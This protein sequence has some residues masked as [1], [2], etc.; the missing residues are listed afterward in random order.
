MFRLSKKSSI[1]VQVEKCLSKNDMKLVD[2]VVQ[3]KMCGA[4]CGQCP[5]SDI[6]LTLSQ[7]MEKYEL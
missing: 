1:P 6:G 2:G 7:Y 4:G 5:D 3:C